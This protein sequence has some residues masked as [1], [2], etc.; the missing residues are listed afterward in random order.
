MVTPAVGSADTESVAPPRQAGPAFAVTGRRRG[1]SLPAEGERSHQ[2]R[3]G[4][5]VGVSTLAQLPRTYGRSAGST[6]GTES[7]LPPGV[8]DGRCLR[9]WSQACVTATCWARL[10]IPRDGGG[11]DAVTWLGKCAG[12]P[13]WVDDEAGADDAHY[14]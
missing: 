6:T 13:S 2:S 5:P 1:S 4:P 11:Q 8:A 10:G 3:N 9:Q 12:M 14:S 7:L